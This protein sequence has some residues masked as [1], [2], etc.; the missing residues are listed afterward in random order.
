MAFQSRDWVL[1]A[2]FDNA[3]GEAQFDGTLHHVITHELSNSTYLS[4]VPR[5]RI[6]DALRLMSVP[7]TTV[8]D[9]PVARQVAL[10]DGAI[11][12]VI[13]GRIETLAGGYVLTAQLVDP[14]TGAAF[15]SLREEAPAG[16]DVRQAVRTVA[17]GIRQQLGES[18]GQVQESTRQLQKVTTPSLQ[19]SRLYSEGYDAGA[20]G[21]WTEAVE[22]TRAA[23]NHDPDFASALIWLAWSLRNTGRPPD[24]YLPAAE[25]AFELATLTTERERY[26]IHGSY[27]SLVGDHEQASRAYEALL[28]LHPDHAWALNNLQTA[29]TQLGRPRRE[30]TSLVLRLADARPNDFQLQARAAQELT[31]SRGPGAARPYVERA[32]ALVSTVKPTGTG[33]PTITWVRWFAVDELWRQR[34]FAEAAVELDALE[35]EPGERDSDWGLFIRASLHLTLGKN[36]R[37]AE[38]YARTANP[39]MRAFGLANA[40][41]ARQDNRSVAAHLRSY[42]GDLAAVSL[43]VRAGAFDEARR[44]LLRMPKSPDTDWSAAEIELASGGG[45]RHRERLETG[46][47]ALQEQEVVGVRRFYYA[48]TLADGLTRAGNTQAAIEVLQAVS[49]L[50]DRVY[51]RS[52]ANG[53][54][55]M[56]TQKRLAELYRAA[57]R[58]TDAQGIELDLRAGL[59]VADSDHPMLIALKAIAR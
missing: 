44:L 34:R 23:L 42:S 10:R 25:R 1:V 52:G 13:T 37:A 41:L 57:G 11:R 43:L 14:G 51:T 30:V 54:L 58:V 45:L 17:N 12:V 49:L 32:R 55:W 5:E 31:M 29:A 48:E 39:N 35:A 20:R 18:A 24:E 53:Y 3:T 33:P 8:V 15:K 47:R 40:A 7:D 22:H 16:T 38:L 2:H 26:F 59:A 6:T 4:V 9:A 28:Q 21:R 19:A 50:R 46:V 27:Y 56:R 36:A